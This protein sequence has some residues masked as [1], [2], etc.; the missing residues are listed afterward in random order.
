MHFGLLAVVQTGK[1]DLIAAYHN[2]CVIIFVSRDMRKNFVM[3][4]SQMAATKNF[5]VYIFA[6]APLA[7]M[8]SYFLAL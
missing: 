3:A 5:C 7:K 4:E 6:M 8:L 1:A 2:V